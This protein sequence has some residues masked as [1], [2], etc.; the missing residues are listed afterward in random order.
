MNARR[1]RRAAERNRCRGLRY[2]PT[3]DHEDDRYIRGCGDVRGRRRPFIVA[4]VEAHHS[5]EDDRC[6][7]LVRALKLGK[8]ARLSVEP[9]IE[10]AC[11]LTA[12]LFIEFRVDEIRANLER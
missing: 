5:L 10:V 1:H 6:A 11:A 8:H 3:V 2:P 7:A 9:E 4:V 12:T